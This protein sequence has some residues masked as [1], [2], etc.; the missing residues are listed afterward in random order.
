[1]VR[2]VIHGRGGQGAVLASQILTIAFFEQGYHSQGFPMFGAERT[3]G[4]VKSF[5][6]ASK[7][8][9]KTKAPIDKSDYALVLDSSLLKSTD[10][11]KT[12]KA[13]GTILIN[14]SKDR[15]DISDKH[16]VLCVDISKIANDIFPKAINTGLLGAF[17]GATNFL[18]IKNLLRAIEVGLPSKFAEP[19][20]KVAEKVYE[21][22]RKGVIMS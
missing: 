16:N 4:P 3:G 19:N 17:A 7:E 20:K 12:V 14:T 2:V 18:Q 15:S 5:V 8:I 9:I 1:M 13:K 11:P 21:T 22:V 10:I 6:R